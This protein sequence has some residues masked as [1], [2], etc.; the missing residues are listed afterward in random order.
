MCKGMRPNFT[1]LVA[2]SALQSQVPD[3]DSRSDRNPFAGQPDAILAGRKLFLASYSGC[4][5]A[6]AEGGRGPNLTE[7]RQIRRLR[8]GSLVASIK[9][10][11]PG[12]DMPPT[13]LAGDQ[14]W[15]LA[16]FAR[17]LSAAAC[18]RN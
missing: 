13:N 4:H 7:G 12:T 10:G 6:N 2:V 16:A 8:D 3:P 11:V 5:G 1:L 15:R 17:A 9:S 14:I 18:E